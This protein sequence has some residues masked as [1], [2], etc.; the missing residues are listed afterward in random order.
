[1]SNHN[2]RDQDRTRCRRLIFQDALDIWTF[3]D[4]CRPSVDGSTS[5]SH[6]R[7]VLTGMAIGLN[8]ALPIVEGTETFSRRRGNVHR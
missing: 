7:P 5:V 4:Q 3:A 1:M 8:S 2:Q 6:D